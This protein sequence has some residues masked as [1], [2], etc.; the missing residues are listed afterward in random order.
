MM[1]PVVEEAILTRLLGKGTSLLLSKEVAACVVV[2][3]AFVG[4]RCRKKVIP[5]K[6]RPRT[7]Q[8]SARQLETARPD[9]EE[10]P[11]TF[12]KSQCY[13]GEIVDGS[14]VVDACAVVMGTADFCFLVMPEHVWIATKRVWARGKQHQVELTYKRGTDDEINLA[15]DLMAIRIS[16]KEM[17]TIGVSFQGITHYIPEFGVFS[18]IVGCDDR[19]SYGKVN[20]DSRVFGRVVY[21]GTTHKGYSGGAYVANN[22]IAGIHTQ[23]GAKVNSGYSSCFTWAVLGHYIR[24]KLKA[25][26]QLDEEEL[27]DTEDYLRKAFQKRKRV[28]V[29]RSW[30]DPHEVRV[31]ID[32]RY[33]V[34]AKEKMR[35]AFGMDWEDNVDST[36]NYQAPWRSSMGYSDMESKSSGETPHSTHP[37]VSSALERSQDQARQ[38]LQNSITLSGKDYVTYLE[39]MSA[40]MAK[41]ASNLA[42]AKKEGNDRS[43]LLSQGPAMSI[44]ENRATTSASLPV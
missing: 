17:S 22:Q 36:G 23:G 26:V 10:L 38:S 24:T 41:Q 18:R 5:L 11:L 39:W 35:E 1:K 13:I 4:W 6:R 44:L 7:A 37:G 9:S 42:K 20:H 16:P 8:E 2:G 19:G 30:P 28:R 43:S 31:M 29:D 32:G 40:R 34:V 27:E 21:D 15:T 25:T 33:A 12:P 14:L 3:G